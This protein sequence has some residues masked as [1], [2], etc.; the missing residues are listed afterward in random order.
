MANAEP[1]KYIGD[2]LCVGPVD[3]SFIPLLPAVPGSSILNG[4]VWIGTGV[5]VPTANCMIGPGLLN[6]VSLEVK[7]I[8]NVFGILNRYAIAN[9][10]GLTT[11][12]GITIR[13]ALSLTN[14]VNVKN[15]LNTGNKLNI[16]ATVIVDK[17]CTAARFIG[18]I[19][20]TTGINPQTITEINLAKALPAKPFDI[21]HPSKEGHRLRHIAVEG[22]EIGV[23]YRGK[24]RSKNVIELPDYWRDLVHEDSITVQLTPYGHYQQLY[25]KKVENNKIFIQN[26]DDLDEISCDF[27]VHAERKD[28]DKLIVE[29]AGNSI[30]DY[31]GQDWLNVRGE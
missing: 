11:K 2:K 7:G 19:S 16:F 23:Y 30:K 12:T 14:S 27:V 31:P 22:P 20:T 25:I 15:G 6:P 4:P 17:T 9:V 3:Y 1:I 13:N 29:Y 8:A 28:M 5:P 10:S 26:G 21:P 24:L 18:D